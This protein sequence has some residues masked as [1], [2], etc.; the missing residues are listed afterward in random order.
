MRDPRGAKMTQKCA[1]KAGLVRSDWVSGEVRL[2]AMLW[3]LELKLYWNRQTFGRVLEETGNRII[4][5]V[6]SKDA[7]WGCEEGPAGTLIGDNQLGQLLTELRG[8]MK[9]VIKG[10]FTYPEGF[11]L[12]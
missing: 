1:V 11:L 3:V 8:R 9:A 2:K 6:S 12:P 5:E 10:E 7:F 4:V